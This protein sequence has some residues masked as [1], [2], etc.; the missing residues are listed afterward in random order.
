[1]RTL[2]ETWMKLLYCYNIKS[3]YYLHLDSRVFVGEAL[4]HLSEDVGRD[5]GHSFAILPHDPQDGSLRR[6][7]LDGVHESRHVLDD[8]AVVARL[9]KTDVCNVNVRPTFE[10]DNNVYIEMELWSK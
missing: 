8:L 5:L 2:D 1:M 10:V 7:H 9:V 6:R 4:G 3:K